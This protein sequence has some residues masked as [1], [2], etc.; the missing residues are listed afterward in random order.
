MKQI[1]S[2]LNKMTFF[3]H[4]KRYKARLTFKWLLTVGQT[5]EH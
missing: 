2:D 4:A 1:L 3:I 5:D